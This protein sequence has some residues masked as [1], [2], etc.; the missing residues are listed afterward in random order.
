[1]KIVTPI[2]TAVGSYAG[3]FEVTPEKIAARPDPRAIKTWTDAWEAVRT[4]GYYRQMAN[5]F[6]AT[7]IDRSET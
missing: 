7:L 6:N 3:E 4:T 5:R 2:E 1:M